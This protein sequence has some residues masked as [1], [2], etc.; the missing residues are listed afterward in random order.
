VHERFTLTYEGNLAEER[1]IDFYD[2][3]QALTGFQRS[4]ALT[5]H[6]VLN[7]EIITQAPALKG[8][9]TFA[10]PPEE[11]SWKFGVLLTTASVIYTLGTAPRET[12]I[13]NIVASAYDYLISETMGFHVDQ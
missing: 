9:R 4:L 11:G 5:T 2:V 6:L 10:L 7:G 1:I 3:A 8:A 13:G 12:A